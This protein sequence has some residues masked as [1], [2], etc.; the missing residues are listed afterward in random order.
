MR[1]F[2]FTLIEVMV[3][4][5]LLGLLATATAWA[6]A[7]DAKDAS[8]R[9]VRQVVMHAD[10]MARFAGIRTNEQV[11]LRLDLSRQ[12]LERFSVDAAGNRALMHAVPLRGAR[13]DRVI[14]SENRNER[15]IDHG[16]IEIDYSST[17]RSVTYAVRITRPDTENESHWVVIAGLT[18]QASLEDDDRKVT[19][20]LTMLASGRR[21]TD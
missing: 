21:L 4:V 2:A 15:I 12:R 7:D 11:T 5:A 19:N 6:L 14:V 16:Q 1:T 9:N 8:L 20:L 18:G 17:G 13:L 10:R 3:V